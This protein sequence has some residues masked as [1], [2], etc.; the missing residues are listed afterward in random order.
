VELAILELRRHARGFGDGAQ[1]VIGTINRDQPLHC[2][3][4]CVCASV[5]GQADQPA[6]RVAVN[7]AW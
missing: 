6:I 4:P 3:G 1:R 7:A 2:T 5:N